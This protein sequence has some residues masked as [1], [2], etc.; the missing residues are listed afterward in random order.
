MEWPAARTEDL[1]VEALGDELLVYDS[2]R[3]R[4]HSL[5]GTAAR[6]WELCDGERDPAALADA[7]GVSEDDVWRALTQLDERRLLE[8]ELPRRMSG[9]EYSRRQAVRRMGLIGASAAF[10]APLVKSIVVPTAAE[11]GASCV[12]L[13]G[14][15]AT[16]DGEGG[17]QITTRACRPQTAPHPPPPCPHPGDF[18]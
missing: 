8:G 7:A 15:C 10:A 11:A 16:V 3:D 2:E 9:P 17:F 4:A 18:C 13:N 6:V 14:V 1:I 12:T 5:N